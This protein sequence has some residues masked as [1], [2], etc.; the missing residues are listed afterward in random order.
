MLELRRFRQLGD[1]LGILFLDPRERF[2][3]RD[4]FEP[5]VG[6]LVGIIGD[7]DG[8]SESERREKHEPAVH[9]NPPD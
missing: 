9:G 7:S 1:R 5:E 4:V 6:V 3:A 8:H 2:L